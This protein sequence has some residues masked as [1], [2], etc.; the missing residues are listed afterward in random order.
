MYKELD[1]II[2]QVRHLSGWEIIALRLPKL[3][4]LNIVF[5]GD[6]V[7]S[8]DFPPVFT[9]KSNQAQKEKPDLEV[10]TQKDIMV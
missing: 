3:L 8:G 1:I 2:F 5:I 6:E 7:M 10:F 9:L 4:S